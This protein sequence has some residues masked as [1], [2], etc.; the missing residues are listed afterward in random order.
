[1]K[2]LT[3][4][5]ILLAALAV[6]ADVFPKIVNTDFKVGYIPVGFDTNDNAQ[7][8]AE[9]T[10]DNTCFKPASVKAVVSHKNKTIHLY[11]RAYQ[12]DGACLQMTFNWHKEIDLG[13]LQT[14]E[15]KVITING[16]KRDELGAMK[17]AAATNNS[18]DDFLYA[19]VS[20]VYFEK[21]DGRHYL[22]VSG[23]FSNTCLQMR[24]I[25]VRVQDKVLVVQPITEELDGT[26]ETKSVPYRELVEVKGVNPGRY[27]IHV[28]S[29]NGKA[30]N[31]LIDV[32]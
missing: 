21:V 14:G 20:Q 12:Y 19:P 3:T 8:V 18:P 17:V 15:Y 30:I 1:M 16:K 11:P 2:K 9:G 26:C 32:D 25:I 31:N 23:E 13:I 27:L 4:I 22:R 10:F 6:N 7:L 5:S 28:R 29:L 24:E